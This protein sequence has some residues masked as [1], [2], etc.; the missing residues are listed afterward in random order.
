MRRIVL[1]LGAFVLFCSTTFGQGA[2]PT[3]PSP[4][5]WKQG[6]LSNTLP[7]G[8]GSAAIYF[9]IRTNSTVETLQ[10][11]GTGVSNQKWFGPKANELGWWLGTS[12]GEWNRAYVDTLRLTTT[13]GR[14]LIDGEMFARLDGTGLRNAGGNLEATL[15]TIITTDEIDSGTIAPYDLDDTATTWKF[16]GAFKSSTSIADS[17]FMTKNYIDQHLQSFLIGNVPA[18]NQVPTY[19]TA[20][21]TVVW[22]DP[23]GAAGGD[24]ILVDTGNGVNMAVTDPVFRGSVTKSGDTLTFTGGTSNAIELNGDTVNAASTF[25]WNN[26]RMDSINYARIDTLEMFA[27]GDAR[28]VVHGDI[29][30]LEYLRS[31]SNGLNIATVGGVT[32]AIRFQQ[33][34]TGSGGNTPA[35]EF[36]SVADKK[37]SIDGDSIINHSAGGGLLKNFKWLDTDS[38]T[39]G[40]VVLGGIVAGTANPAMAARNVRDSLASYVLK[41]TENWR[42]GGQLTGSP[43]DSVIQHVTDFGGGT[44]MTLTMRQTQRSNDTTY[45]QTSTGSIHLKAGISAGD[46]IVLE[47]AGGSAVIESPLISHAGL[48]MKDTVG[49]TSTNADINDVN[50]LYVDTA[51]FDYAT[52]FSV[53]ASRSSHVTLRGPSTLGSGN[54]TLTL[55]TD[56]GT[57]AQALLTDGVGGLYWGSVAGGSGTGDIEGVTA[58]AGLTGGGVTG[59][60]SLAVGAGTGITVNADDIAV[61]TTTIST[62]ARLSDT[63]LFLRDKYIPFFNYQGGTTYGN[64]DGS[65][66]LWMQNGADVGLYFTFSHSGADTARIYPPSGDGLVIGRDNTN[67]VTVLAEDTTRISGVLT[68]QGDVVVTDT[69][70]DSMVL[71]LGR[72]SGAASGGDIEGVGSMT[73]GTPFSDATADEDW[74]GLGATAG[75]IQFEANN[76]GD[77]DDNV[78]IPNG[79]LIIGPSL[80]DASFRGVSVRMGNAASEVQGIVANLDSAN[81]SNGVVLVGSRTNNAVTTGGDAIVRFE[82]SNAAA[83]FSVDYNMGIDRSDS[84]A[85]KIQ[86]SDDLSSVANGM[87]IDTLSKTYFPAGAFSVTTAADSQLATIGMVKARRP[88]V[89]NASGGDVFWSYPTS[90]TLG[91]DTSILMTWPYEAVGMYDSTFLMK[92][93]TE[94]GSDTA[95]PIIEFPLADSCVIDTVVLYYKTSNATFA[96]VGLDS[97]VATYQTAEGMGTASISAQTAWNADAANTSYTRLP[98]ALSGATGTT[99]GPGDKLKVRL[100]INLSQNNSF[101]V[102]MKA[103]VKG[104]VQ[105]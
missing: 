10:V 8:S 27:S 81:G 23:P 40:S 96:N 66:S 33:N 51:F 2:A 95:F 102:V 87:V 52:R 31:N 53:G 7:S 76:A 90:N 22:D 17:A 43:G 28:L 45:L 103:Q 54:Y 98:I 86:Y 14:L 84:F 42:D 19:D 20:T 16:G 59:T 39:V 49:G 15:G 82:S 6:V 104:S 47:G 69:I 64:F 34:A 38:I 21:N 46:N 56:D 93:S 26:S 73:T 13:D 70:I 55:P 57:S 48:T 4:F 68:F 78:E 85:L 91:N 18:N 32:A 75:R 67:G 35:V 60:V 99:F 25:N 50:A 41:T 9:I 94:A 30:S 12:D 101:F 61:N 62:V 1:I 72:F 74:L 44:S 11:Q 71:A 24:N 92:C 105:R 80:G 88:F 5:V 77:D 89:L 83:T 97:M 79:S 58:D 63:S 37:F 36:Y 65:D 3:S 100:R 29:D